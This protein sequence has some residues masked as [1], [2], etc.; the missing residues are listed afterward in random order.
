MLGPAGE[1]YRCADVLLRVH[2]FARH[3]N[4]FTLGPYPTDA[5]GAARITK[6]DLTEFFPIAPPDHA[7][8][9]CGVGDRRYSFKFQ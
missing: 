4:D 3:R 1:A 5:D 6:A 2:A 9:V 7:R 8:K